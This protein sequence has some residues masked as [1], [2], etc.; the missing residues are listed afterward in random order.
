MCVC[1]CMWVCE[2]VCLPQKFCFV[3][4]TRNAKNK[5][6]IYIYVHPIY[7]PSTSSTPHFPTTCQIITRLR[8]IS[9][10]LDQVHCHSLYNS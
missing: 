7:S 5:Y 2:S 8:A 4:S 10:S 9:V 1:V 3:Y 6:F